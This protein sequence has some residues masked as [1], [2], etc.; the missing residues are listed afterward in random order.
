MLS[1]GCLFVGRS[2]LRF[3]GHLDRRGS[4]EVRRLEAAEFVRAAGPVVGVG[5][6][7]EGLAG[8]ER[9]GGVDSAGVVGT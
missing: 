2:T 6:A 3:D 8:V 4:R 5:A 9:G 7:E 1:F